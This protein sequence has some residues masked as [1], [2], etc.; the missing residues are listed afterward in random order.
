MLFKGNN[1]IITIGKDCFLN[2]FRIIFESDN[3]HIT[4][5]DNAFI[6]DDTRIYE[7]DGSSLCVGEGCMFSD[8][9]EI[10]T[11]DNHSIIDRKTGQRINREEDVIL[12]DKVW[13]GTGV[14]VLK[15]TEIAD[16]CIVGA[17]SVVAHR[18]LTPYT[19]IA[20][21]PG[22]EIKHDVECGFRN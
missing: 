8:R 14:T 20:G 10:R 13:L 15:G 4:I 2:G 9:I 18:Y 12:H 1:N 16:G 22:K 6:L 11:T 3:N 5:G 21:N 19:V 7:V 17:G